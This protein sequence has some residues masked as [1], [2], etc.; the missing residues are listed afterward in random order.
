MSWEKMTKPKCKGGIGFRDLRLFNQALLAKQ[1]WRLIEFRSSLCARLLK[2]RYYPSGD[3]IDT[4]FIKN[5]STCWQGIT[6]GLELLKKGMIWR[7]NTGEKIRI[8]RDNWLPRGNLKVIGNATRSRKRWVSDL[9]VQETKTWDEQLVRNLFHE[10]DAEHILQI[11]IPTL[12]GE[13]YVAWH[14][15]KNGMFSVKSAYR[16]ALEL[17]E[18]NGGE[19]SSNKQAGERDL[20]KLIW[21]AKVQPK[22]RTFGWKL[23]TNSLGVQAHR[24]RR[25]MDLLPTC[26]ICGTEPEDCFHAMV[27]CTKA[28]SLRQR[29]REV[30]DLPHEDAF[31]FTGKDWVLILLSQVDEDMRAKLLLLWWRTWHLRNNVIFGD[32]KCG[33]EHSSNFLQSYLCSS[34]DTREIET[35]ADPKGKQ[36]MFSPSTELE[37]KCPVQQAI[38]TKPSTGWCKLNFDAGFVESSNKGSWGAILRDEV[39][40]VILSAWGRL[41]YCASAE[42]AEAI[43]GLYSIKAILPVCVRPVI[44]ENDCAAVIKALQNK[45]SDKSVIADLVRDM[46]ELLSFCPGFQFAKV[47]RACN[48]VAHE[49]ARLG[50]YERECVLF[51][52]APPCV[53]GLIERECNQTTSV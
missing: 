31:K 46:Q 5:T 32:G 53:A 17:Q 6:H 49:L 39:G 18:M 44:I 25:K 9:I 50:K 43:A 33:I 22:V 12:T 51:D 28:R 34:L 15:E 40:H 35:L 30:W 2:A 52:S 21:G 48:S 10:A 20:W 45:T 37:V 27:S 19:G 4:A 24:C 38:W 7:I 13:D 42:V 41:D 1:A 16:L 3:L 26:S 29:L 11:K 47:H 8:W 36:P 14:Y 23:A